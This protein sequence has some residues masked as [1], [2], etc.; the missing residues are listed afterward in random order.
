[1]KKFKLFLT[2][3]LILSLLF[4]LQLGG[5]AAE[6]LQAVDNTYFNESVSLNAPLEA[7]YDPRPLG[8]TTP[9]KNQESQ[10]VCWAFAATG[11]AE[12][13][14]KYKTG[15]ELSFSEEHLRYKTAGPEYGRADA[16]A[17]G[18][19]STAAAYMSALY[20]AVEND[21]LDY[22]YKPGSTSHSSEWFDN[23]KLR[24]I[25]SG[26]RLIDF[27]YNGG[28]YKQSNIDNI[29]QGVKDYGSVVAS[30]Y[31]GD[32]DAHGTSAGFNN[33]F[34]AAKSAFYCGE[35]GT[36]YET[37]HA[38]LI[39][40]WDDN[41][42]KIN[43]KSGVQPSGNGAFLVKNSWGN[44]SGSESGYFWLSYYDKAFAKNNTLWDKYTS[45]RISSNTVWVF[46][47]CESFREDTE[48]YSYDNCL[49]LGC[50]YDNAGNSDMY[51]ANVFDISSDYNVISNIIF[52]SFE[53]NLDY[54][55]YIKQTA[56]TPSGAPGSFGAPV[57]EGKAD[58]AGY[59]DIKLNTPYSLMGGGKYAVILCMKKISC[60]V[61]STKDGSVNIISAGQSFIYN[62]TWKDMYSYGTHKA[63]GYGN[64]V[65][66]AVA[67]KAVATDNGSTAIAAAPSTSSGFK[68][69]LTDK[70]I[71]LTVHAKDYFEGITRGDE[72]LTENKDYTFSGSAVTLKASFLEE[73]KNYD[74]DI[75]VKF[76]QSSDKTISIEA[77]MPSMVS[78]NITGDLYSMKTLTA[79]VVLTTNISNPILT[80]EW[81]CVKGA[82]DTVIGSNSKTLPLSESE[83]GGEIY[84]KVISDGTNVDSGQKQSAKTAKI[85]HLATAIVL[86][87]SAEEMYPGEFLI[88][89]FKDELNYEVTWNE[90]NFNISG[91]AAVS[92]GKLIIGENAKKDDVIT[93]NCVY[94]PDPGVTKQFSVTVIVFEIPGDCYEIDK[95]SIVTGDGDWIIGHPDIDIGI[96][97]D[98][99]ANGFDTVYL[100]GEIVDDFDNLPLVNGM[101]ELRFLNSLTGAL[102]ESVYFNLKID[103]TE[104][105]IEFGDYEKT[106]TVSK[107]DL[108]LVITV[109]ASDVKSLTVNGE[110]IT[111]KSAYTINKNGTYTFKL[112]NGAG[113]TCENKITVNNISDNFFLD[114]IKNNLLYIAGGALAFIIL[115]ALVVALA[116]RK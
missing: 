77:Y 97:G 7:S 15:R 61:S 16:S 63:G 89:K 71:A 46:T 79:N 78:V 105:K 111:G 21:G 109:G 38:V 19:F 69:Q 85:K 18:N 37:N 49:P 108:P 48:L 83:V 66:K 110:D 31:G 40:G 44:F 76:A 13:L 80:Y 64:F 29:K 54:K 12:T 112:T 104:P 47:S 65:I 107:I 17:G 96:P 57:A 39:V 51:V 92:D 94:K 34:N 60:E 67:K 82:S 50:Y 115:I 56:G 23:A 88:L 87:F 72:V 9:V 52:Y 90:L 5:I 24:K 70:N 102:T 84:V 103:L 53:K 14:V 75:T 8:L 35:T 93:V 43:F 86:D 1:M 91:K 26:T 22:E 59:F 30:M 55:I 116:K 33:Y 68:N 28:V 95:N 4:C 62:G 73:I 98:A 32:G 27:D 114:F 41:F 58:A 100:N 42:A 113:L 20:G 2:L 101:N 81:R 99:E 11:A 74:T 10:G 106:K 36:A 3:S 25:I 45:T 6:S